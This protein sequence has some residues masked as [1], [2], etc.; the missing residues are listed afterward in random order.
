MY[1]GSQQYAGEFGHMTIDPGGPACTCGDHGCVEA[2]CSVSAVRDFV[3]AMRERQSAGLRGRFLRKVCRRFSELTVA[4]RGGDE[5]A[6][7][8]FE[9]MGTYLGIGVANL[10]DLFNPDLI[11]LAGP[12]TEARDFF[13]VPARSQRWRSMRACIRTG[14]C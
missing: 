5:A 4:A 11:V 7:A 6:R 8:G 1:R 3:G 2:Y 10:V 12:M 14:S 13:M 9:R